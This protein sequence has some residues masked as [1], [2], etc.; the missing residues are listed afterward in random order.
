MNT[1]T[2]DNQLIQ[3]VSEAGLE[4]QTSD[5]IIEKL[6]PFFEQA[7]EWKTKAEALVVTSAEQTKEMKEARVARL[8]LKKIR[9]E[10]NKT[11]ESLKRDSLRYGQTVQ[12]VYNI[13]KN[14]I[15]PIEEHLQ[16]QED[17]VRI[18]EVNRRAALEAL[19]LPEVESLQEYIP[20]GLDL[21]AMSEEDYSKL[22]EGARLQQQ[23]K[24]EAEKKAEAERLEAERLQELYNE[25]K[26]I[27]TPYWPYIKDDSQRWEQMDY[28]AFTNMVNDLEKQKQEHEAEQQRIREEN[29]LLRKE[30][31]ER[32][33]LA[34]IEREKQAKIQAEKD[35]QLKKEREA[36]EA[37]LK[38]E[39]EEKERI[40]RELKAKE[41]AEK[42]AEAKRLAAIAKEE[43]EKKAA[44]RKARLAP[45]KTK[46][47]EVAKMIDGIQLP[48]LK[49]K[50]GES[51]I[52]NVRALLDKVSKYTREQADKL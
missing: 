8:E 42:K 22:I 23:Q 13:I 10:A 2:Q 24:I 14:L 20:Y 9:V 6:M 11:R 16:A 28:S 34:K 52:N 1:T 15:E 30:A 31:A 3:V 25:R 32:E 19:R 39:R 18:Q 5:G 50:E 48:T 26:D 47:E 49:N 38:A 29:D 4:K 12:S 40:E 27:L 37:K 17:F 51:I 46:L 45:D 35:A 7:S 43:K 41:E 21:G 44:E 36:Q 33:R